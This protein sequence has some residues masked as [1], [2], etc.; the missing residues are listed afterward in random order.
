M[1]RRD[2]LKTAVAAAVPASV[3]QIFGSRALAADPQPAAQPAAPAATAG[4][5]MIYRPLGRTGEKVSLLG[6]GGSHIGRPR[7]DDESVR[8]MRT[9]VDNGVNFFDNCWDY[10]NG[11][12]EIRMGKALLDGYRKKIFL[13]TKIDGRT[14]ELAAKQ[15]DECLKRLQTDYIDLLQHHEVIRM[16]D[17]DR[18]F[19]PN[20]SQE[21]M[22]A[23]Q[24]AGKI[25]FIGFT[26]HKDP[27]VFLRM[28][29][30]AAKNN[31]RFDAVQMPLSVMDAHFRSF[32]H[33]VLPMLVKDEIGV[34]GMKS[35]GAGAILRSNTVTPVE[36]LYYA[37]SLP[38]STLIVG[39]HNMDLL[40]QNLDAVRKFKPLTSEEKTA[41]LKKTA[42][43]AADGQFERFKTTNGFDGTARHP[44]WLG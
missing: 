4:G 29:E 12:C 32:E 42:Q 10:N 44:E 1:E 14:K 25:R 8:I 33:Q 18:I 20:G 13:M 11:N 5:E 38:V 36:C 21:A 7:D 28:L 24:K 9:A 6:L 16:E 40:N 2:F 17:P 3:D 34:L 23:A 22:L 27:L 31:C 19:A 30:I 15:I 26:G 43:A 37:M 39:M 35:F 41:L